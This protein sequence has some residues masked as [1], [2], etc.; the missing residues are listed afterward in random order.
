MATGENNHL[1]YEVLAANAA[2][3]RQT[4]S[5]FRKTLDEAKKKVEELGQAL[6]HDE[7]ELEAIEEHMKTLEVR[8]E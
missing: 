2:Y 7:A 5:G 8:D 1:V 3:L 6:A 4:L